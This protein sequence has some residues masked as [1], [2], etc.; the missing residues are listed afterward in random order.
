MEKT[1][2]RIGIDPKLRPECSPAS[3]VNDFHCVRILDMCTP[4][5]FAQ[6]WRHHVCQKRH[7]VG[8]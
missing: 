3:F 1:P 4:R 7:E 2:K 8:N 6:H 5:L